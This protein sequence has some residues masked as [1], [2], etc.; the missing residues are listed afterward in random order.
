MQRKRII[1]GLLVALGFASV[2]AF[3]PGP[4]QFA[5]L[6][7]FSLA[8][9]G[10]FYALALRGGY[11]VYRGVGMSLGALWLFVSYAFCD[12]ACVNPH[13][14]LDEYDIISRGWDGA[15]LIVSAFVIL[16]RALFDHRVEHPMAGAGATFLGF[17]YVPVLTSF[18]LHLAQW[19]A[20][21][22]WATT[23]AG[24]FLTFFFS[25]L[26]KMSDAGAYAVGV[27]FGRHKLFPRVSPKKSWE[28]L[29]GG[30]LVG[31][32]CGVGLA[33]FSSRWHW[34]PEGIF[35]S[36]ADRPA[37]TL[38]RTAVLSFV[39]VFV[40]LFGD[41]IESMFK[42]SVQAKDSASLIPGIG[43]LLDTADSLV[44]AAPLT[45]YVLVWLVA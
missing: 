39:L 42:R 19:E 15:L 43:G 13:D 9:Q 28:G 29:A 32:L 20:P 27:P 25:F 6:L 34:G 35:W 23:R 7:A 5:L 21:S 3:F 14:W 40:G 18:Y 45:Y 26:I 17:L 4:F 1:A 30:L 12:P 36:G 22:A 33:Y 38:P 16:M 2:M 24:V 8:C 31:M 41:L 11:R 10:E 37:L 44:F